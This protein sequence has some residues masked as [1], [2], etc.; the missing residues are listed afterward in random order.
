MRLHVHQLCAGGGGNCG[1]GANLFA[2]GIGNGFGRHLQ[3]EAAKILAVGISRMRANR[4]SR[5]QGLLKRRSHRP[6]VA[7]VA[8]AGHVHRRNRAHQRFL[9]A[10]RNRFR[11]LAHV[12]I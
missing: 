8:A 1:E 6:F 5:S 10:V 11:Q 12:A 3:L 7:R 2:H 4:N 9:R